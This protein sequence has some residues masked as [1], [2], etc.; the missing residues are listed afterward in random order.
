MGLPISSTSLPTAADLVALARRR[1]VHEEALD[2][3]GL[4][5]ELGVSRATAYRWAG[6]AEQLVGGV[7]ASLVSETFENLMKE[8]RGRGASRV[9]RIISRGLRQTAAFKPLRMFL[10]QNPEKALSIV[11]S[12]DGP[13]QK[14]TIACHQ[15]LLE[16]E[17]QKGH[18]QLPVDAHTMA[19]ALVRVAESFLYADLIAGEEPDLDKAD[20]ILQLMLRNGT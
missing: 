17:M 3:Q 15:R 5:E 18:L 2:L 10:E 7:I 20:K 14:T 16:E 4:A 12:K 8:T 1:F 19:Y 6:N 11:A 13:V 9:L